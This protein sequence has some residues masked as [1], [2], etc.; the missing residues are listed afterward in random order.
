MDRRGLGAIGVALLVYG[1]LACFKLG[2][3]DLGPDEG[4]FGISAMNILADHRQLAIVSEEPLGGPGWKPYLY[5][6]ML[7]ASMS[8]GGKSELTLR[9]VNVIAIAASSLCLYHVARAFLPRAGAV[10]ALVFLLL[11][12]VSLR[13]ARTAMPEPWVLLPGCVALLSAYRFWQRPQWISAVATGIALGLGVLAKLWLALPF[14]L[15]CS[16]LFVLK[17]RERREVPVVGGMIA[18]LLSFIVVATSHIALALVMAPEAAAHWWRVYFIHYFT[19]RIGG[20]D[21]DPAMWYRP[22]W[23]YLAALFKLAAFGLPFVLLGAYRAVRHWSWPI[24]GVLLALLSPAVVFSLFRVKQASY[25]IAAFPAVALLFA[26]GVLHFWGSD[27]RRSFS[28]AAALAM[29]IAALLF[30]AGALSASEAL[31]LVVLYAAQLLVVLVSAGTGRVRHG[32]LVAAALV[33][34]VLGDIMVVR[35]S[36]QFRTHYRE[37]S[38]YFRERL[39]PLQPTDLAFVAP[40]HPSMAF[41]TFRSGEYW[42]TFYTKK[43]DATHLDE[44]TRAARAFYIVDSS[45]RLYGSRITASKMRALE[46]LAEDV[47]PDIERVVGTHIGVRAFVPRTR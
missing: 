44:L 26:I 13:Y 11:N 37:I 12:P 21:Y 32:A 15:A 16:V 2:S 42:E 3:S 19:S 31:A 35:Q 27:D 47:T 9:I 41:Y 18:A 23:F 7:A 28:T 6:L 25:V 29:L 4:R 8:V 39:S 33:G 22:W 5:P 46:S 43:D 36:L 45:G 14:M 34:L 40:E 10:L 38:A 1:V 30:G 24:T 17:L 20:T